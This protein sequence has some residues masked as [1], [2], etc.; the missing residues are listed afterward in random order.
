MDLSTI[1]MGLKL[2]NPLVPS[3][4]PLTREIDNIKRM[5]DSGAA[6]VVLFS[7]F[8]EQLTHEAL[9]LDHYLDRDAEG[10]GEATSFFP[11]LAT[12][13]TGPDAYLE[14]I[15]AAK[16]ATEIPIIA[17]LNGVT[18]GGWM[19][20]A[21]QMEKAGADAVELNIYFIPTNPELT[22]GEIEQRYLEIISGVKQAVEIP[23]AV[24]L[25]PFFSNLTNMGRR[26]VEA[27]ADALVLF[28][29]FYQP[30]IDLEALE[31]V[32]NLVLSTPDDTRLPMRWL[33]ILRGQVPADLAGSTG[34]HDPTDVIKLL[35]AGA[36]VTMMT[37]ALL[38][39][40]IDHLGRVEAGIRTWMEEH[41][42]ESVE[43]MKGSMSHKSCPDPEAFE[44]GNY[45][46]A[47]KSYDA[48]GRRIM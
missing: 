34:V 21:R 48:T 26:M 8:E 44:R 10:Y 47:L 27:G 30:D 7:L 40:G 4:S 22:G 31:V 18:P 14:H 25:H 33:A 38:R 37:A 20:F 23:V 28:N 5:E 16:R 13:N 36:D 41:Q 24:K 45:M 15:A 42:Y 6:A 2:K 46:R 11:N 9:E 3:A 35:M 19:E 29:R 12:Y 32:P 17:S 43:Q 1:Y 39:Y